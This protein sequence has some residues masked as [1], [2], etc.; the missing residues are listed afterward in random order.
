MSKVKSQII[1]SGKAFDI[2]RLTF[3]LYKK[4]L[5]LSAE[6]ELYTVS[7]AA[8][9]LNIS[10]NEIQKE[11]IEKGKLTV[12]FRNGRQFVVGASIKEFIASEQVVHRSKLTA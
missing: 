8:F 9:R 1:N 5:R 10:R 3:H 11:L 6:R 4:F 7:Q 12:L 2:S